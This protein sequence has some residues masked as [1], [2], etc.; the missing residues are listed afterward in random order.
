MVSQGEF[1]T[2]AAQ[3]LRRAAASPVQCDLR[4]YTIAARLRPM[5][6][7]GGSKLESALGHI[8]EAARDA[9]GRGAAADALDEFVSLVGHA[10][11]AL[12]GAQGGNDLMLAERLE[13]AAGGLDALAAAPVSV[14][15]GK[16]RTTRP[17]TRA[18]PAI[19]VP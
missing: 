13:S 15:S 6:G 2:A 8:A 5:V 3:E 16:E 10:A 9:I 19:Q 18:A 14:A 12:A 4:L 11:E 1:L 7:A 17:V